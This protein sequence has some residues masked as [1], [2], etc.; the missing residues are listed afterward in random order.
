MLNRRLNRATK[1]NSVKILNFSGAR[2][3]WISMDQFLTLRGSS[4]YDKMIAGCLEHKLNYNSLNV[5]YYQLIENYTSEY[6]NS[7]KLDLVCKN[8]NAFIL[9]TTKYKQDASSEND[10]L[11]YKCRT[12]GSYSSIFQLSDIP[13]LILY[14]WQRT[15][16]LW[17]S[18]CTRQK[19]HSESHGSKQVLWRQ[20]LRKKE[21]AKNSIILQE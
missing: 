10:F 2:E 17:S 7:A 6:L 1:F 9:F 12:L 20:Y 5:P 15:S 13:T 11:C 16:H 21:K 3:E 18:I 8:W 4:S 14:S 19:S